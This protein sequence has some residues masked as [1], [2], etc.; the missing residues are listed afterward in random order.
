MTL[1]RNINGMLFKSDR[2]EKL[3]VTARFTSDN[4]GETLSLQ[5][6]GV[7][8]CVKF[9]DIL[10]M[11]ARERSKGYAEGHFIIDEGDA[12]RWIPVTERLPEDDRSVLVYEN[13]E[14]NMFTA[15]Y[16]DGHWYSWSPDDY[17]ATRFEETRYRNIIAWMPLPEPYEEIQHET[18]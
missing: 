11:V 9:K 17:D 5:A 13:R 16:T 4:L 12:G 3:P 14:H 7:M 10:K 2:F 18:D 6:G 8:I 1:V 15:Y